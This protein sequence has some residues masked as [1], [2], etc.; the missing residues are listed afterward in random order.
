MSTFRTYHRNWDEFRWEQEIRRDE[1]RI[2]CYFRTLP[3]CLDLPGEEEMIS[4][5]IAAQ[6]DLLPATHGNSN[7]ITPWSYLASAGD[8]DEEHD[9]NPSADARRPGEHIIETVDKLA[10]QWNL[11]CAMTPEIAYAA[12]SISCAYAKLLAR[13]ADFFDVD[14]NAS[15]L[16]RRLGKRCWGDLLDLNTY[17]EMLVQSAPGESE[18]AAFQQKRLIALREQISKALAKFR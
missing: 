6:S 8:E 1:R 12:L 3:S 7:V 17:L 10:T 2:N 4:S 9:E 15:A 5:T 11:H 14:E 13:C 16:K 18:F